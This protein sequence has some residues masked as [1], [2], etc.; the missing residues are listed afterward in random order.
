MPL[1]VMHIAEVGLRVKDLARMAT[2]YQEALGLEIVRAYWGVATAREA[3]R[4][5]EESAA[6]SEAQLK[7]ARQRFDVG[8]TAPNEVAGFEAQRSNE[9]SQLIQAENLREGSLIELRRLI[10]IPQETI[11][12]LTDALDAAAA[13]T[14]SGAVD[15]L[16]K[17]ALDS[18]AER[19]ALTLRIGGAE[20]R[21][22]AASTGNKP[23]VSLG[24][25]VDY[26]NPNPK[27]F[28]RQDK[29]QRSWD[30]GVNVNW[31]FVDFGRSRSQVAD[32]RAPG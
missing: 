28:P 20:E 17:E 7:D 14:P 6:R 31:N 10:G 13:A 5:L 29:L 8:L 18:R 27:H 26:A 30:V 21:E 3:V 22:K 32:S 23:T 12:D 19:K 16:V 11:V 2:F 24:G 9:R 4:V 15:Q 1:R 25:G